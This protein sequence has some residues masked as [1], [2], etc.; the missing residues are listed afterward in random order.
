MCPRQG[1]RGDPPADSISLATSMGITSAADDDAGDEDN[2]VGNPAT[3]WG[4]V[5]ALWGVVLL[6]LLLLVAEETAAPAAR[7]M[8]PRCGR[9]SWG[10]D[11]GGRR[12][13]W[14]CRGGGEAR[15]G[16]CV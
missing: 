1:E 15:E 7:Y 13:A 10:S 4:R 5:T 12:R 11:W 2:N 3:V 9:C 6:L 8:G 14:I 16:F